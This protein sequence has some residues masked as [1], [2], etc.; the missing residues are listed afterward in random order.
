M[1]ASA[2]MPTTTPAARPAL[3]LEWDEGAVAAAAVDVADGTVVVMGTVRTT[4][5]PPTVTVTGA[6][7]VTGVGTGATDATD[8]IDAA[9]AAAP[10]DPEAVGMRFVKLEMDEDTTEEPGIDRLDESAAVPTLLVIPDKMTVHA[11]APPPGRAL[12]PLELT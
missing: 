12:V 4:V 8:V 9:A 7:V 3:L 10:P 5:D 1:A 11:L 6:T 2:M